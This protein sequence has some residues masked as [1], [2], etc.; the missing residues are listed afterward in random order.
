MN[1]RIR[2]IIVLVLAGVVGPIPPSF[3]DGLPTGVAVKVHPSI[4]AMFGGGTSAVRATQLALA[5]WSEHATTQKFFFYNGVY[6]G[7]TGCNGNTEP[8]IWANTEIC[9]PD[10]PSCSCALAGYQECFGGGWHLVFDKDKAFTLEPTGLDGTHDYQA[11]LQH[12]LGHVLGVQHENVSNIAADKCVMRA[13]GLGQTDVQKKD[14]YFCHDDITAA[15]TISGRALG[16][17]FRH[18]NSGFPTPGT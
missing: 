1:P 17:I 11:V 10:C 18:T 9:T 16:K 2:Q 14:R 3:A 5:S 4:N 8:H 7:A 12:E 6:S 15:T 13:G